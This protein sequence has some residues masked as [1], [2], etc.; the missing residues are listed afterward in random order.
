[1]K[2]IGHVYA[3]SS[4]TTGLMAKQVARRDSAHQLGLVQIFQCLAE[5]SGSISN[6]VTLAF[7][8]SQILK[9]GDICSCS[10][11]AIV[12]TATRIA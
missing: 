10:T 12:Q 4:I 9:I 5:G 7:A 3:C 2:K 11:A 1:M 8:G 6:V